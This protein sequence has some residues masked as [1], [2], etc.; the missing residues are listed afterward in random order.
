LKP[1][2]PLADHRC[3]TLSYWTPRTVTPTAV[4]RGAA[5]SRRRQLEK[6]QALRTVARQ[7]IR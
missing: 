7:P 5:A 3:A 1:A 2:S 6:E 4:R